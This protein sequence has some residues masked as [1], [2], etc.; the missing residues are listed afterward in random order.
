[1]HF[2]LGTIDGFIGNAFT[3]LPILILM[4]SVIYLARKGFFGPNSQ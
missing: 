1:M 4:G 2:D 3:T